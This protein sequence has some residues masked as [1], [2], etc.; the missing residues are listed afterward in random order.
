MPFCSFFRIHFASI[1]SYPLQIFRQSGEGLIQ[2]HTYVVYKTRHIIHYVHEKSFIKVYHSGNYSVSK[3]H[4][5]AHRSTS[6][7]RGLRHDTEDWWCSLNVTLY[8]MS[9]LVRFQLHRRDLCVLRAF[10]VR[11]TYYGCSCRL[12]VLKHSSYLVCHCHYSRVAFTSLLFTFFF[13]FSI[14][15]CIEWSWCFYVYKLAYIQNV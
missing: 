9:N 11:N 10:S 14:F 6:T 15:S 8:R 5:S 12:L 13:Y 7:L 3:K 1:S 4:L 2:L